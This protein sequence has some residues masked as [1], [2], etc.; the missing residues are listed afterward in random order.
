MVH[1]IPATGSFCP[2]HPFAPRLLLASWVRRRIITNTA[3]VTLHPSLCAR[4]V[5]C[6]P[7]PITRRFRLRS[8]RAMAQGIAPAL[9]QLVVPVDSGLVFAD[10][11][12]L[13]PFL[14]Q[15]TRR[16]WIA[17]RGNLDL[18]FSCFC[19]SHEIRSVLADDELTMQGSTCTFTESIL[20]CCGFRTGLFTSPHLID[21]R[22]R[23]RLDG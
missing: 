10:S 21:V 17:C 16:R 22:E 18:R 3:S 6:L 19:F 15:S 11:S 8:N 1:A 2:R 14:P 23:F 12:F 9:L 7:P 5:P 4:A 13:F 20:R